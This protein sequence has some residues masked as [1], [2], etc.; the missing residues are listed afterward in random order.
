MLTANVSKPRAT[1]LDLTVNRLE[2]SVPLPFDAERLI[3]CGWV[4]RDRAALQAHIDELVHLGVAPPTR[5]PIYMNFSAYLLTTDPV[6]TVVSA[7]SSGEVEYVLLCR[8][9]EM[10]VTVGS[11]QTDRDVETKSI[12]ASKQMYAKVLAPECW[13]YDDVAAH[14]D[15]LVLRCWATKNGARTLYQEATLDA[16]LPPQVLLN[17][18]PHSASTGEGAVI[19]SGTIPTRGG[20]LYADA[21]EISIEDPVR[22]RMIRASYRV[23]VLPQHL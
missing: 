18:M 15:S 20:L 2:D 7:Q 1:H 5:V 9:E 3:C 21:Y 13:R 10:W 8:G 6:I 14:W 11:D 4:G 16:I 12:P 23:E 22:R 17:D 19:F